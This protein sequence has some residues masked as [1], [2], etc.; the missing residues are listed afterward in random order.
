MPL[1]L[2]LADENLKRYKKHLRSELRNAIANVITGALGY[3]T[4]SLFGPFS[5]VQT[6]SMLGRISCW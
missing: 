6:T 4:G 5:A 2:Q 1:C 3:L